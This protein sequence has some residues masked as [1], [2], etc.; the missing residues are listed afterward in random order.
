[1]T[2]PSELDSWAHEHR[3]R[4]ES[5][6]A[7]QLPT[8]ANPAGDLASAMRYSTL[9]GGKRIRALLAYAAGELSRAKPDILDT[10]AGA[11]ELIHAYSLIHD[12][13]PA[14]DNDVLRRGKPTCHVQFGEALA[15]LA[16]DALQTLAFEK[17]SDHGLELPPTIQLGLVRLLAKASGFEGM[18][19]GQAID[20]VSVQLSLC[21]EDLETMHAKKTGALISASVLMGVSCGAG[22]TPIVADA[23]QHYARAIGLAFQVVDDILDAS[24]DTVTLGK[25]AGKDALE[26]KPTFVSLLGIE[27]AHEY[28]EALLQEALAQIAPLGESALRLQQ[29]ATWMISRRH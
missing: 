14:M 16:G 22:L 20:L 10:V 19:G 6:L 8:E 28:S 23:L 17:L 5:W 9:G 29:L 1:M 2:P 21:Q 12:D 15:L 24:S 18:A 4:V 3:N 25:T 7:K 11:I 13:M 27:A 26:G